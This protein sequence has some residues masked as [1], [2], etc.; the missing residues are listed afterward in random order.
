MS[1]TRN[2]FFT[3]TAIGVY[4][5]LLSLGIAVSPNIEALLTRG[6]N[7]TESAN[8]RDLIAITVG[9]FSALGTLIA[10]YDAGGVY[11]PNGLPGQDKIPNIEPLQ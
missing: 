9:T 3:K 1:R 5:S 11:T 4:V 8:L 6:K 10:R 7:D 2:L